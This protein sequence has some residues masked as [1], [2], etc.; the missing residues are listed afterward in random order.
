MTCASF[1][2]SLPGIFSSFSRLPSAPE[3]FRV[4]LP[5]KLVTQYRQ[6]VVGDYPLT[7]SP[8]VRRSCAPATARRPQTLDELLRNYGERLFPIALDVTNNNQVPE[9]CE[10]D[11]DI[12]ADS[13]WSAQ[14]PCEYEMWASRRCCS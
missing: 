4:D 11:T 8:R 7:S 3:V 1:L 9:A 2:R 13:T 5:Q 12:S 14:P 6:H 10:P